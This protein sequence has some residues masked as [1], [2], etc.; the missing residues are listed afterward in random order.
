[1]GQAGGGGSLRGVPRSGPA[2][3]FVPP[4]QPGTG[5]CSGKKDPWHWKLARPLSTN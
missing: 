3:S 5:E 2:E 1:M 4:S